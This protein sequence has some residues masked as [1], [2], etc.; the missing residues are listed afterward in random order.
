MENK[1]ALSKHKE[2]MYTHLQYN[3]GVIDFLKA[4]FANNKPLIYS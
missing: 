2:L 1:I 4:L 3:V